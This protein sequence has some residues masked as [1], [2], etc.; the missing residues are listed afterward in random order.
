MSS[1]QPFTGLVAHSGRYQTQASAAR[2]LDEK[3]EAID[4]QIRAA[5][6]VRVAEELRAQ[7]VNL[8][9]DIIRSSDV[10]DALHAENALYTL[11]SGR[12]DILGIIAMSK[13][14]FINVRAMAARLFFANPASYPNSQKIDSL[15]KALE[16]HDSPLIRLGVV[17]GLADAG[18]WEQ[19][20]NF[21]GD[22]HPTVAER[23]RELLDEAM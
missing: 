5:Q 14:E 6:S 11:L 22:A 16:K 18:A 13:A 9:K 7:A 20:E 2:E 12:D 3:R 17:L 23:A 15:H 4:Q 21:S 1:N 10:E 8:I 19:V